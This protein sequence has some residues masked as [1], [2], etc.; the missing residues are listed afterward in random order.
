[1]LLLSIEHLQTTLLLNHQFVSTCIFEDHESTPGLPCLNHRDR[2]RMEAFGQQMVVN[3]LD[4]ELPL[5]IV[6]QV[7]LHADEWLAS[8]G[9]D[10]RLPELR[11]TDPSLLHRFR[12]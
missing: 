9:R 1:M 10:R 11:G 8:D 5:E 7:E 6:L 2:R 3:D 4:V 12:Q